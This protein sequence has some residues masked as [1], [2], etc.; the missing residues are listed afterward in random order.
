MQVTATG[1]AEHRFVTEQL[2]GG[3]LASDAGDRVPVDEALQHPDRPG[4]LGGGDRGKG[5]EEHLD[6]VTGEGEVAFC[7]RPGLDPGQG[8]EVPLL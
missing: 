4:E 5:L 8:L 3:P 6:S 2:E 1:R 7:A